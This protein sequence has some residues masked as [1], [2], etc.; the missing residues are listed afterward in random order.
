MGER[1]AIFFENGM[2]EWV[3]PFFWL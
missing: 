2:T 1:Q 3:I